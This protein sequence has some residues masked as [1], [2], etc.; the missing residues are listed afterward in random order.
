MNLEA[1]L[2]IMVII[3]LCV[4]VAASVLAVRCFRRA[5]NEMAAMRK[6]F[7]TDRRR[8]SR[9]TDHRYDP[10]QFRRGV[11]PCGPDTPP[12]G[13]WRDKPGKGSSNPERSLVTRPL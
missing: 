8:G 6:R 2:W 5:N 7:E 13:P 10:K 12:G 1:F 3:A 4:T 11:E 9:M